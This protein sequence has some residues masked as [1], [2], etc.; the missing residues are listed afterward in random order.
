MTI[1]KENINIVKS[2]NYKDIEGKRKHD[3]FIEKNSVLYIFNPRLV[4]SDCETYQGWRL[5]RIDSNRVFHL[6]YHYTHEDVKD[7]ILKIMNTES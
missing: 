4:M 7:F 1:K 5:D 2:F 6:G 3:I